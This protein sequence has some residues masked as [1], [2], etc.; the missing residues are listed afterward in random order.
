M[1]NLNNLCLNEGPLRTPWQQQEC[2]SLHCPMI[3]NLDVPERDL[4]KSALTLCL[5]AQCFLLRRIFLAVPL[6]TQYCDTPWH[7]LIL[8]LFK[9]VSDY[10]RLSTKAR[11]WKSSGFMSWLCHLLDMPR[12]VKTHLNLYFLAI[13][14]EIVPACG[15][16]RV[17][18][19][20]EFFKC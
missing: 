8:S 3:T 5:I 6:G 1:S 4:S 20:L 10:I 13:K 16:M 18:Y 14:M 9:K 2:P 7:L 12:P 15:T 11:A 19:G 17:N